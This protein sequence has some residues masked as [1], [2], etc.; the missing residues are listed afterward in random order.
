M[1]KTV[2]NTI[3]NFHTPKVCKKSS[4]ESIAASFDKLA[5]AELLKC[6]TNWLCLAEVLFKYQYNLV[7]NAAEC[8]KEYIING[9][10]ATLLKAFYKNIEKCMSGTTVPTLPLILPKV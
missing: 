4:I 3:A 1:G 7:V 8:E 10:I 5:K 2:P 9:P 6:G